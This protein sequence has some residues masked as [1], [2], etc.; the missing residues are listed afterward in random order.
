MAIIYS[1]A[2]KLK[3][4]D[5]MYTHK[6]APDSHPEFLNV[7]TSLQSSE[8]IHD[9]LAVSKLFFPLVKPDISIQQIKKR[10]GYFSFFI[11][12]KFEKS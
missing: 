11:K 5:K 1:A 3:V 12:T 10:E 8:L 2:F 4:F 7:L 9:F 6:K